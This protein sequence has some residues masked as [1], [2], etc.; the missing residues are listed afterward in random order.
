MHLCAK[1]H[2]LPCLLWLGITYEDTSR[3]IFFSINTDSSGCC[4][5]ITWQ[6]ICLEHG[7]S[8]QK[9]GFINPVNF[10]DFSAWSVSC[11]ESSS[12]RRLLR[13]LWW[14]S[15]ATLEGDI[16]TGDQKQLQELTDLAYRLFEAPPSQKQCCWGRCLVE[17]WAGSDPSLAMRACSPRGWKIAPLQQLLVPEPL[18]LPPDL[19]N[20]FQNQFVYPN[21]PEQR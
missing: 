2:F 4:W 20:V 5:S 8:V 17:L 6:N 19:D 11:K 10:P 21:Y 12:M 15:P 16:H 13:N 1:S 7:V 14:S 9:S 18:H 3:F